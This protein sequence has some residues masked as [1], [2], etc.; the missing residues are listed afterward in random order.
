MHIQT[1]H[2]GAFALFLGLLVVGDANADARSDRL[3][4]QHRKAYAALLDAW[5][6]GDDSS[7]K[8]ATFRLVSTEL[9]LTTFGYAEASDPRLMGGLIVRE[10]LEVRS[11]RDLPALG[12]ALFRTELQRRSG[13]TARPRALFEGRELRVRKREVV[14]RAEQ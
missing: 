3:W 8:N 7:L 6:R 4:S 14:G 9:N 13:Y 1:R 2:I 11:P 12:Y 5:R 10:G